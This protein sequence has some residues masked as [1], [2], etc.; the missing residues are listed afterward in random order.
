MKLNG[1]LLAL[2]SG[3]FL[4][5]LGW[6]GTSTVDHGERLARIEVYLHSQTVWFQIVDKKLERL[7]G[8]KAVRGTLPMLPAL[9]ETQ[10][11]G[12]S[13]VPLADVLR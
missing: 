10:P 9:E 8:G 2:V 11:G 7:L 5:F 12:H 13:H 1:W 3:S 4:T 6:V